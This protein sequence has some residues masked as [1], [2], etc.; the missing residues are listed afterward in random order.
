VPAGIDPAAVA[1]AARAAANR[2]WR[3]EIATPVK[4]RRAG[5]LAG[6]ID[7]AWDEQIDTLLEFAAAWA[8]LGD[9]RDARRSVDRALAARKHLR[10]FAP[11]RHTLGSVPKSSLDGA[12]ETVLPPREQDRNQALA[13][14]YRIPKDEQLDAVGLVKRAGGEPEQFVPVVNVALASWVALA[15]QAAPQELERLRK[16][17]QLLGLKDV[18]RLPCAD[19]LP[20]DATVLL[21]SRWA[22]VFEELE[23]GRAGEA[24][25]WGREHVAP[26]LHKLSEPYPYVACLVA[27]GDHVGQAIERIDSADG[28]REFSRA[29]SG[30]AAEARKIVE[31]RHLGSLVYAGGDDTLAFVP[32]PRALACAGELRRGFHDVM[33][34]ACPGISDAD[35]PTLSVGLGVGHVMQSMTELL[36]LGRSALTLAKG[37]A[38]AVDRRRDALAVIVDRRSG[39]T[40]CWRSRWSEWG[41]DPA[42][43]LRADASLLAEELSSSKLYEIERTLARLPRPADAVDTTWAQV[44]V[45]EVRRSLSRAHARGRAIDLDAIGL[46]LD[47]DG[48]A[49]IHAAVSSWLARMVV[50]RTFAAAEPRASRSEETAS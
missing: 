36:E 22:S 20:F 26:L 18:R 17:C 46:R 14:R 8:P 45:L 10:D 3:D 21:R 40:R 15:A 11:W 16:A 39:G 44:L 6:G 19:P 1:R 35:R 25:R 43:R 12:R 23:P 13:R 7:A 49:A 47:E 34:A 33:V 32:L 28:H 37:G 30:F 9:Y 41:G 5:L 50:A 2:H 4:R 31:E 42:T 24:A 27:D 29:L 38:L 48:Y